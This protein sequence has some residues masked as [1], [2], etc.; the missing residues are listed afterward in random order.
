MK[1]KQAKPGL[2][3]AAAIGVLVGLALVISSVS[4]VYLKT[5]VVDLDDPFGHFT[6]VSEAMPTPDTTFEG[7][8]GMFSYF[9]VPTS[10]PEPV[11][12]D[13]I[14]SQGFSHLGP[15]SGYHE[16]SSSEYSDDVLVGL[17]AEHDGIESLYHYDGTSSFTNF[18]TPELTPPSHN[19]LFSA[20]WP[21]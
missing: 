18:S 3:V 5:Q 10:T 13:L 12:H 11:Q 1:K 7:H 9:P 15:Q 17:P 21:W 8:D 2:I 4:S 6:V 16:D 20:S 19:T 14:N